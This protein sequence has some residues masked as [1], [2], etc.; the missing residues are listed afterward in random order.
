MG[1]SLTGV[2]AGFLL[3]SVLLWPLERMWP[4]V[5]GQGMRR[6]G[7]GTDVVYWF[8]TPLV[9]SLLLPSR[10]RLTRG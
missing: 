9:T 3:L 5:A 8:F 4:S 6:R 1:P 7:F 2:I 10:L